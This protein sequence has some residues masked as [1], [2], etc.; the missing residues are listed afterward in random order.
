MCLNNLLL[1]RLGSDSCIQSS[2]QNPVIEMRFSR[3]DV[4]GILLFNGLDPETY[5]E[6]LKGF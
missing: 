1:R 3:N 2:Q 4:L 5:T 6:D